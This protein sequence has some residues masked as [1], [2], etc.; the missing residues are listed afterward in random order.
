MLDPGGIR[1][2]KEEWYTIGQIARRTGVSAKT[3]RYYDKVGLLKP[4]G[5]TPGGYRLYRAEDVDRLELILTLRH[6]G[7]SV[8]EIRKILQ[9]GLDAESAIQLQLQAV[10]EQIAQLTALKDLLESARSWQW[11]SDPFERLRA[12]VRV[13][14]MQPEGRKEWLRERIQYAVTHSLSHLTWDR[15][16]EQTLRVALDTVVPQECSPAQAA[17]LAEVG[18]RLLDPELEKEV[19]DHILRLIERIQRNRPADEAAWV[20]RVNELR[21]EL[22]QAAAAGGPPDSPR[23]Q[24]IVQEYN[25]LVAQAL[26][27][28]ESEYLQWQDQL[29]AE[30]SQTNFARLFE[31]AIALRRRDA[32]EDSDTLA[33]ALLRNAQVWR[34]KNMEHGGLPKG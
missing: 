15:E 28:S 10:S 22:R 9:N 11:G 5:T 30:L 20:R 3:I 24:G 13:M 12:M 4:S 19:R 31:L 27:M 33:K 8:Q 2:S 26:G 34:K 23:V 17:A 7:Y 6:V 29:E 21:H 1:M 32:G 25:Q 16:H 14:K 18:E